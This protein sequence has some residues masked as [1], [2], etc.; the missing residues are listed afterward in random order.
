M[1][2]SENSDGGPVVGTTREFAAK[3]WANL[4]PAIYAGEFP[5]H[6]IVIQRKLSL[7]LYLI[8]VMSE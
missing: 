7:V 3:S 2:L 4:F 6:M 8:V 1:K 5:S